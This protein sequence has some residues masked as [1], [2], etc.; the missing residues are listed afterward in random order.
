MLNVGD[1]GLTKIDTDFPVFLLC[2]VL[3]KEEDYEEV[4][5]AIKILKHSIW[6]KKDVIFHS[7]DTRKCEKKIQKLFDLDVKNY[8]YEEVIKSLQIRLILS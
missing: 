5:L 7:R 1:H 6:R 2:G 8:F 4:R 3:I